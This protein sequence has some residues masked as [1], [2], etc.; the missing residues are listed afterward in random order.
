[1]LCFILQQSTQN[2]SMYGRKLQGKGIFDQV[3]YNESRWKNR[4]LE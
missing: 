3:I 1:M 4:R 2:K